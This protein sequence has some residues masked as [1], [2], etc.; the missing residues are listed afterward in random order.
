MRS[1]WPY[2][3]P[4][5]ACLLLGLLGSS[6]GTC[7][8]GADFCKRWVRQLPAQW[9]PAL[10][11]AGAQAP[12]AGGVCSQAGAPAALPLPLQEG[13][14]T[15]T[16]GRKPLLATVFPD[17]I[18]TGTLTV[19]G[20]TVCASRIQV[21]AGGIDVMGTTTLRSGATIIGSQLYANAGAQISPRLE[22][23]GALSV[24]A[25]AT[26]ASMEVTGDATTR[27]R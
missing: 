18:V 14:L 3:P 13:P 25:K 4:T 26:F 23:S 20:P 27:G 24:S 1:R 22:T 21:N 15:N 7:A 16:H 8:A 19:L 6:R 10:V 2:W 5:W 17:V 9:A 12:C 11:A